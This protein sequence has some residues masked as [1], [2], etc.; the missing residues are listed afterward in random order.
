VIFLLDCTIKVSVILLAALA[1]T[2]LLR[3][4]SAAVRHAVLSAAVF[5]A[6][7]VPALSLV[8]PS[9]NVFQITPLSII[10]AP[11]VPVPSLDLASVARSVADSVPVPLPKSPWRSELIWLTG[12]S[13]GMLVLLTGVTRLIRI[14]RSSQP[15]ASDQWSRL[16]AAIAHDY[17]IRR[18][19]GLL[20]SRNS[21]ILVTWGVLRPKVILPV[22]AEGWPST[23][24]GI[25]LGHELAHIRRL[26]WMVQMTA[27]VLRIVYWFNPLLWIVCR[28]LRLESEFACDDAVISRGIAGA[29]YADHLL[30]LARA[31]N[32][33]DRAWSAAMTMA[34]PSNIERR[35]K[36]ML[37][38]EINR[39]PATRFTMGMVLGGALLLTLVLVA[40]NAVVAAEPKTALPSAQRD[41]RTQE[42]LR[43]EAEN[44]KNLE[45]QVLERQQDIQ[46]AIEARQ[47]AEPVS[48]NRRLEEAE[49]RKLMEEQSIAREIERRALERSQREIE[50]A[51]REQIELLLRQDRFASENAA[52]ARAL[53]DVHRQLE[54]RERA[55]TEGDRARFAEAEL[56]KTQDDVR[57][58][59]E[60]LRAFMNEMR[61]MMERINRSLESTQGKP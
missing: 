51:G 9:W 42:E 34:G 14:T 19:V 46:R 15:L 13:I 18:R 61:R 33:P 55:F 10:A 24:A 5:C 8:L 36:A 48:Q 12:V 49:L 47:Q 53:E 45:R 40:S 50:S 43:R 56:L 22:G 28:R 59:Q 29:E 54:T 37:N 1:L 58:M 25:V 38:P 30:E 60:E 16:A 4:Q 41:V 32:N 27:Q 31:L 17:R 3:R 35:F 39:R 2:S 23:R 20:Q 44:L 26:D 52:A 11:E 21:S 57:R 7:L 6:A